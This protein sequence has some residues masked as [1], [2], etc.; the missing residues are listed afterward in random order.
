MFGGLYRFIFPF[1]FYRYELFWNLPSI[2]VGSEIFRMSNSDIYDY[3]FCRTMGALLEF[4]FFVFRPSSNK[5]FCWS[6]ARVTLRYEYT[7]YMS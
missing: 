4:Y 1:I 5:F 6:T 3:N 2:S 7:Q